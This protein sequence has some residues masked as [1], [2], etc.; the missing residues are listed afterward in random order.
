MTPELATTP[1]GDLNTREV[2][3]NLILTGLLWALAFG[4]RALILSAVRSRHLPPAEV[5]RTVASTRTAVLSVLAIGTAA[6]WFDELKTFALSLAAVAAAIV[7]ATKEIILCVSGTFVRT[8]SNAF[9]IGDRIECNGVRG[10]V[11][12]ITLLTT[13]IL[14]IGPGHLAHQ[15]TGRAIV[16]P[17]SLF[18]TPTRKA[19]GR[20]RRPI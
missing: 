3:R 1:F 13:K 9:E 4:A 5:R 10:D 11:I 2:V 15:Q 14:E 16:I 7:L 8:S 6:L 20:W 17:N 19:R 12:D 18:R